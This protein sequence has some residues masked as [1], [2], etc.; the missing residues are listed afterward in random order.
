M[1]RK[2]A[3]NQSNGSLGFI[4]LFL[5]LSIFSALL[6]SILYRRSVNKGNKGIGWIVLT[7]L[8]A[9][10]FGY[11]ALSLVLHSSPSVDAGYYWL[12]VIT[13]ATNL[14]AILLIVTKRRATA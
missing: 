13:L 9:L 10:F 1:G 8:C 4:L 7:I 3:N 11:I 5:I 2:K 14:L 12:G 6:F